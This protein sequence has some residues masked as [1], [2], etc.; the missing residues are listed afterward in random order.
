MWKL[1]F[2]V[3]GGASVILIPE[4]GDII[5][6]EADEEIISIDVKTEQIDEEIIDVSIGE[7]I[8]EYKIEDKTDDDTIQE[9]C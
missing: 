2:Y 7:T 1:E 4:E 3:Y 8:E 5:D 9:C 6:T